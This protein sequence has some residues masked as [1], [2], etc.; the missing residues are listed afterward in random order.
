MRHLSL[1]FNALTSLPRGIGGCTSLV[2][3]SLN[4]NHL[5]ALP[6]EVCG[7]S[8]LQRLSLHINKVCLVCGV[9]LSRCGG[10]HPP[11]ML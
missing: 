5:T 8:S 11:C 3:L 6:D 7:L 9:L 4:A 10:H 2:W 1:H